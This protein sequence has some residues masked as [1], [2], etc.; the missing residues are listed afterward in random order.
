MKKSKN[1]K[2]AT[3]ITKI[4][5]E[6]YLEDEIAESKDNCCKVSTTLKNLI[7][8]N[9]TA[10]TITL[11]QINDFLHEQGFCLLL[12]IFAIPCVLPL[13]G[14]SIVGGIPL[15]FFSAQM[16]MGYNSP[17]LPKWLGNKSINVKTLEKM[18]SNALPYIIK[19][20]AILKPRL[21]F[22]NVKMYE[23]I[24]GVIS[25]IFAIYITL[26]IIFGNSLPSIGICIMAFGLLNLDGIM[27]ILG[28][29]VGAVGVIL[30]SAVIFFGLTAVKLLL[31]NFINFF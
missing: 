4:A 27:I 14:I 28:I 10:P 29:I 5:T 26:P 31:N 22:T 1:W 20:E 19:I 30:A 17:W 2:I 18:L 3:K 24:V 21:M 6:D 23:K 16:I 12:I 7:I 8:D 9:Q 15:M 11:K 13:P 25:L